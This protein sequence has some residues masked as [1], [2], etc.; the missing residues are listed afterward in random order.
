MRTVDWPNG[1]RLQRRPAVSPRRSQRRF[2]STRGTRSR[3]SSMN[4]GSENFSS[5]LSSGSA[6]RPAR[7][8]SVCTRGSAPGVV[9]ATAEQ[10]QFVCSLP[11]PK[12]LSGH[13]RAPLAE[14]GRASLFVDFAGDEMTFLI[15]VV[16]D[17]SM[18]CA[19]FLERLGASEPLH[20]SLSSSKR[21]MRVFHPIVEATTNLV[22][23]DVADL[24]HRSGIGGKPV[25]D[26]APRPAIFHHDPLQKLQRRGLVPLRGDHCFQNL[27]FV[28][29]SPPE[30]AE[31]AVDLHKDLIQMPAPLGEAVLMRYPPFPDLRRE[32]RAKP[33]PPKSDGLMA[34]VDPPLGQEILD[35]P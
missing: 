9:R 18:N 16:V 11:R 8:S 1:A 23:I 5:R 13:E 35:V 28:I 17:M 14:R 26:D 6:A 10:R 19:E 24:A 2:S 12:R 3:R 25:G 4:P 32:H 15:E 30:I 34:D 7:I 27:A 31:L 21:L 22:A 33:V 29:D 20:G